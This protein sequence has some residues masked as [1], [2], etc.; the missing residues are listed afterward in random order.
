ME[1]ISTGIHMLLLVT[2][3]MVVLGVLIIFL[4]TIFMLCVVAIDYI[5]KKLVEIFPALGD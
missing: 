2:V 5:Y 1:I 3:E 4:Y